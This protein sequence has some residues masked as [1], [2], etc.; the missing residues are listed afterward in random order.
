MALDKYRLSPELLLN[1][2]CELFYFS[3]RGHGQLVLISAHVLCHS[4]PACLVRPPFPSDTVA[5]VGLSRNQAP[6][7]ESWKIQ[8]YYAGEPREVNTSSSEA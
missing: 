7:S 6:H 1:V 4:Q 2:T 3:I 5:E 8:V